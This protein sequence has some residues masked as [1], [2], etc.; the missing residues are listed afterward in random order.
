MVPHFHRSWIRHQS[1]CLLKERRH[2]WLVDAMGVFGHATELKPLLT[3]SRH[4]CG[5]KACVLQLKLLLTT[6]LWWNME[7]S[8]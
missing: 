3:L 6:G 2:G 1:L 5:R 4:S 8:C 7:T